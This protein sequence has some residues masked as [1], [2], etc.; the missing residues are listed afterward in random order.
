[1]EIATPMATDDRARFETLLSRHRGI[2]LK[3]AASYAWHA[4]DRADLTQD[5]A[6]QLWRAF[7]GYDPSRPFPTWMYRIA[8]NVA[9]G[10]V[11]RHAPHSRL[12]VPFDEAL[13]DT[14][15]DL[16]N[17]RDGLDRMRL[18]QRFIS[19]Q[20]PLDRALLLL[21]LEERSSREMSEVL[22]IG[23]SNV[24]TKINRLKQRLRD[25]AAAAGHD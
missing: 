18:L 12:T 10:H 4:E 19:D 3:I 21:Y 14:A 9:I 2:V 1:M 23:E 7:P 20:Q 13:H 8:L 22:G 16:T 17:D 11:R 24:T 15:D 25:Y 6:T 5:I